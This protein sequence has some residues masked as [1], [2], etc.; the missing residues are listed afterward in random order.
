MAMPSELGLLILAAYAL[1]AAGASWLALVLMGRFSRGAWALG[2]VAAWAWV[3]LFP[4]LPSA[5]TDKLPRGWIEE[6]VY[7]ALIAAVV[8]VGASLVLGLFTRRTQSN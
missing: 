3:F 8:A 6:A 7:M 1:A 2:L 4:L 5:V